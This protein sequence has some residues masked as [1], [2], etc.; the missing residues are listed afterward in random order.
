MKTY[1][2][3]AFGARFTVY[4]RKRY[5]RGGELALEV[6]SINNNGEEEPFGFITVNIPGVSD[7]VTPGFAFVK[8]YSENK[9]WAEKLAADIGGRPI[10]GA[11]LE[12]E[13]VKFT[14]WDFREI[15]I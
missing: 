12:G 7:Q 2:I 13:F 14:L 3:T 11:V 8:N 5:Y 10:P 15:E 4:V 9:E 6:V 1:Q